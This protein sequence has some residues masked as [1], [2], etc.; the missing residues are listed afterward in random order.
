MLQLRQLNLQ[1]ALVS[2]CPLGKDIKNQ[3]GAI[4]HPALQL[5]LQVSLLTR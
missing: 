3:A 1:F 4:K 2:P 5:A